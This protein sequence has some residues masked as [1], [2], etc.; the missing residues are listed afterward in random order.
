MIAK[1]EAEENQFNEFMDAVRFE[2]PQ[3][4]EVSN[5]TYEPFGGQ[6]PSIV[7]TSMLN[8]NTQLAK[9][10]AAMG[11]M[12]EKQDITAMEIRGLRQDLAE[13]TNA[14]LERVEADI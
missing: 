1:I 14:R 3:K 12:I 11:T 9:G 7:K 5:I 6:V 4:A 10:I 2:R 13:N 8:M